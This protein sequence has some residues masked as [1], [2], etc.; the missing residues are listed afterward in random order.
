D[1]VDLMKLRLRTP[2]SVVLEIYELQN[3]ATVAPMLLLPFIEN[4][5]KY[6]SGSD[7]QHN[8]RIL[9]RQTLTHLQLHV[10][11]YI[12]K[13]V[14]GVHKTRLGIANTTRRLAL[15]YPDKHSLQH[16]RNESDNTYVV[17][18]EIAI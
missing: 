2:D 17:S 1:Y 6:G 8:I 5:F 12:T 4:A 16:G 3:G 18:L 11:N 7:D 14:D 10:S 15:L 9:I 13:S